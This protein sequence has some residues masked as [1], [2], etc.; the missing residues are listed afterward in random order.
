M[1]GK[2]GDVVLVKGDVGL[3]N[4]DNTADSAK[5][6]STAQQTAL[7]LKANLASPTFTGVPSAPTAAAGT[8]TTQL[9]TTA[10][11]NAE[12][13]ANAA[14]LAHVGSGG[15]AHADVVAGGAAGFMTGAD[16]SKLDG[17]AAGATTNA[18]DAQLRDRSTH[19][20]AQAIGTVTGLQAALDSKQATL[21]SGTNIKTVNGNSLLGG[22][23]LPITAGIPEAPI[24][25]KD[26]ARKDGAWVEIEPGVSSWNDLTDKP[27]V[28][29]AG[30]TAADARSAIGAGTSNFDGDYNNLSNKP[31][32]PAAQ[33]QTDWDAVSGVTSIANKPAIIAAG[34]TAVD[35]RSAIGAGTSNFDG[36]YNNL[37]N[38]PT[39][40]AAQQQ[41][42]WNAVSGIT[43][44]ANK[45]AVIAA[46]ADQA[47]ARTAIDAASA[48][49]LAGKQDTLVSGTNIKTVNG[50]SLLGSGDLEVG[51]KNIPQN[52]QSAAYTLVLADAGKH[53]LHP[54]ADT[55][56]RTFTIPAN[57]SVAYP[58]G[59]AITFIN[60]AGTG[61]VVSI[62]I[63]TDTVRL[64][65]AGTTGTRTL[66]RNGIATAVKI[67]TTEWI[68]SGT[69]L[70]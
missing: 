65:G 6:V 47:T 29:A 22:G 2:Q 44:I 9:A 23:D 70:T 43:S 38:K 20:G 55:T 24:N 19:T 66:A 46:G 5:P 11:V 62:G 4:V 50:N 10:Y 12:I 61:G 39:I 30:A 26:H 63:T 14:P 3:G 35:A 32:I 67:A 41:T 51:Y 58:I 18:T 8:D 1:A 13:A 68:I 31:T 54:A 33:Q 45:P 15:A 25:G 53:I 69:G 49:D 42:D 27:A 59:T 60:Q 16:K 7:D 34:A 28:I 64:A 48:S 17:I 21:V 52:S 56:A 57:S 40:P 37:S 36:D